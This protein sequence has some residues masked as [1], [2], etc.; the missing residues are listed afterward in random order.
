MYC[1]VADVKR[2]AGY[3]DSGG[4]ISDADITAN[5]LDAMDFIDD[6]TGTVYWSIET[7]GTATS[8]DATTITDSGKSWTAD[9]YIGYV[10]WVYEGTNAGEYRE[11]T[12]NDTTSLTVSP[13]F[14]AAIDN[15][16]KYRVVPP[17]RKNHDGS[18]TGL[19]KLDGNGLSNMFMDFY[20]IRNI[21]LLTIDSTS[22]TPSTL[23]IKRDSGEIQL[24]STSEASYFADNE[25]QLIA[26]D[27][28]Y[29]EYPIPRTVQR[30]C[31]VD[32]ALR[33]LAAQ[34]GATYDDITSG[35]LPEMQFSLGEPWTNIKQGILALREERKEVLGKIVRKKPFVVMG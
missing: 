4:P 24:G 16:S 29:G 31:A 2:A 23:I 3:P 9:E 22:I 35:S 5:I 21:R 10:V 34:I 30:L 32:A 19:D 12:D 6:Y 25:R 1:T 17:C 11:I 18:D 15:T 33:S 26:I 13:A 14:S 27:Y 7:S 8:G 28:F 20:P